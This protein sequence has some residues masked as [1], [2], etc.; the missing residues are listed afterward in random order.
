VQELLV[1]DC[2]DTSLTGVK[3]AEPAGQIVKYYAALDKI[4]KVNGALSD[5]VEFA[6]EHLMSD[7]IQTVTESGQRQLEL[8]SV[9]VTRIVSVEAAEAVLPVRH[10][11]PQGPEVL[12]TDGSL[13]LAI[14]HTQ[15]QS[16]GFW[17]ERGPG[18]VG[19]SRLQLLGRYG[20]TSIRIN[21]LEDLPEKFTR[22][23]KSSH[24]RSLIL[25]V[26]HDTPDQ[27]TKQLN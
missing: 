13:V 9:D 7:V 25:L 26:S 19:Q 14:E 2:N 3:S 10:V 8:I 21:S 20:T 24:T 11:L 23:G 22:W 1:T 4:V 18:A 6:V 12:E 17:V 15:H 27:T 5:P 16:N